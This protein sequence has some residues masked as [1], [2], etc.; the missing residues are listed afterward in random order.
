MVAIK[1]KLRVYRFCI[2]DVQIYLSH[3]DFFREVDIKLLIL[4]G[5]HWDLLS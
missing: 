2:S 1:N 3:F 4:K 5:K